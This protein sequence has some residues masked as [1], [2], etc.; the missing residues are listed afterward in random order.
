M[1][2]ADQNNRA[3]FFNL[4]TADYLIRLRQ[5]AA[6]H[7]AS[8]LKATTEPPPEKTAM[9]KPA[10]PHAPPVA[11]EHPAV[12]SASASNTISIQFSIENT[13]DVIYTTSSTRTFNMVHAGVVESD[14]SRH[15]ALLPEGINQH[16]GSTPRY[17]LQE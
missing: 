4:V 15:D 5:R 2:E 7:V 9:P 13:V 11:Y 14:Q 3:P 17:T 6:S 10:T 12:P 1:T 8:N 16:A